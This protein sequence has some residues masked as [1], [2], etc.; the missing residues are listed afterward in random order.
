MGPFRRKSERDRLAPGP[1]PVIGDAEI[2]DATRLMNRWDRSLG[3]N[4]AVWTCL[5]LIAR[6]GGFAGSGKMR[7]AALRSPDPSAV[8]QRPWRWWD[9]AAHVAQTRGNHLLPGRIFLFTHLFTSQMV[10]SMTAGDR[11]RIG[12][13]PPEDEIYRSIAATAV[14]SLAQLWPSQLIHDTATGRVDVAA[15]L[16]MAEQVSGVTAPRDPAPP[17]PAPPKTPP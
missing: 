17:A 8:I 4:D 5:E 11:M 9:E 1:T 14:G 12:L 16:T 3:T 6:R 2:A 15:A 10:R 13:D 7:K